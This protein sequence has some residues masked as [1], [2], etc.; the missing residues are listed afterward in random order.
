MVQH[1]LVTDEEFADLVDRSKKLP[2]LMSPSGT[3]VYVLLTTATC[4]RAERVAETG[5]DKIE[6]LVEADEADVE[7]VHLISA[8]SAERWGAQAIARGIVQGHAM[9]L[10]SDEDYALC[11]AGEKAEE[12]RKN[13]LKNFFL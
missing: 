4:L 13:L 10:V 3:T 9:A 12:K 5:R 2:R 8:F 11:F 6:V 7:N 1:I